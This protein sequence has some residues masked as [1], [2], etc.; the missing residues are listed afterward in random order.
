MENKQNSQNSQSL[1]ANKKNKNNLIIAG[2][3]ILVVVGV[4]IYA[5]K[6]AKPVSPEL[7]A[8][9]C[10]P[11]DKFSQTS[12]KPCKTE[13]S[14]PEGEL[15]D[16]NTGAPCIGTEDKTA[17]PATGAMGY[18]AALKTYAGKSALF[19][20]TCISPTKALNTTVGGKVLIAN[21]SKKTLTF[22]ILGRKVILLPYH[23]TVATPK[24]TGEFGIMCNG[25]VT[26]FI[27]VK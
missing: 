5:F 21:N 16:K 4:A 27:I 25:E 19:D 2:I 3:V 14:C 13:P 20:M 26:T 8:E 22:T 24:T 17:T 1:F 6:H 23:Y 12:G 10:R 18:E 15:F 7:L 11:G 9:G